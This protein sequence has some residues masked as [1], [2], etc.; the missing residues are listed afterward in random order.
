M[1]L[2]IIRS[3]PLEI[4]WL[5]AGSEPLPSLDVPRQRPAAFP[6]RLARCVIG[7]A[8]FG[9]GISMIV[10]ADLGLAPW[11]VFHQGVADKLG[12]SIGWVIVMTGVLLMLAWIPLRQRPG[13]GTL[14]NATEI[15]LVVNLTLPLLPEPDH[16]V[17][18][19][20]LLT[21]G[22]LAMGIGSGLYIGAGL[23]AGPRDGIML[24]LAARGV[25]VRAARTGVEVLVTVLGVLLGGTIGIGTV[26]FALGIGPLVQVFLPVFDVRGDV[27]E[28]MVGDPH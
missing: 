2:E 1:D 21:G 23:G 28:A 10:V 17:A 20:A 6:E 15:G 18:R 22:L 9:L 4:S 16:L 14:L 8:G 27:E 26:A 11:D 25:S 13:L 24:G 12:I 7:L 3:R 19:A 5:G